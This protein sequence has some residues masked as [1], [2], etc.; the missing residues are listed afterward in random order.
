MPELPQQKVDTSCERPR[1][2]KCAGPLIRKDWPKISLRT[3][4]PSCGHKFVLL[5]NNPKH[6]R[7]LKLDPEQCKVLE[8]A[9]FVF[10]PANMVRKCDEAHDTYFARVKHYGE[11]AEAIRKLVVG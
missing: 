8:E 1:C 3:T 11:V 2:P 4:C 7:I 9:L 6:T 10:E 5:A